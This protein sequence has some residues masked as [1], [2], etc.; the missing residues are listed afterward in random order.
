MT[1]AKIVEGEVVQVFEG[2]ASKYWHPDALALWEDVPDNIGIAEG[3]HKKDDGTWVNAETWQ[4]ELLAAEEVIPPGPPSVTIDARTE[5]FDDKVVVVATY[6]PGGIFDEEDPTHI[7][8]WTYNGTETSTDKTITIEYL[9]GDDFRDEIIKCVFVGTGGTSEEA[10][11]NIRIS[12]NPK[13]VKL[14]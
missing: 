13:L 10:E 9:K 2:D 4:A 12:P 5:N 11:R 1:W 8:T 14:A 3:W 6:Y 7:G